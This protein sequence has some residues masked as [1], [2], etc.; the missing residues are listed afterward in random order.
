MAYKTIITVALIILVMIF[1]A[2]NAAV[3]EVRLLIWTLALPRSV[4]IFTTL[5]I[6][7]VIGWFSRSMFRVVRNKD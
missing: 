4:L 7:F 2:Q 6:G 5:L 3:V 1:V